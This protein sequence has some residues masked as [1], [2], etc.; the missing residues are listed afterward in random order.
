MYMPLYSSEV[1][2]REPISL[3]VKNP[4]KSFWLDTPG[5][6]PLAEDGSTGPLTEDADVCIIGSGLTGIST[7]WHLSNMFKNDNAMPFKPKPINIVILEARQFGRNG[8]NLTPFLA[9]QFANRSVW[10]ALK[11]YEIERYTADALVS[12]ITEKNL[13]EEVGLVE[14]GHVTIFKTEEDELDARRELKL[15]KSAGLRKYGLNQELNYTGA[16]FR[17]H[18]LWPCK[19]VTHLFKDSQGASSHL[20]VRLHTRTPVTS[21][22]PFAQHFPEDPKSSTARRRRWTLHTPRGDVAC[23]YVVH[24]TNAYA[25]HLLP[26]LAGINDNEPPFASPSLERV[27]RTPGSFGIVPHRGQVGAVRASV[28]SSTLGWKNSW[29]FGGYDSGSE[30]W[31]PRHQK[32]EAFKNDT[33][34]SKNRNPVIILGGGRQAETADDSILN[35]T[36]STVLRSFLPNLFPEQ[37][38]VPDTNTGDTWEEEWTGIMGFTQDGDPFVGP[39]VVPLELS[40]NDQIDTKQYDGQYIAAGFSGHGMP[41][42]YACAQFVADMVGARIRGLTWRK[43]SWMP[44]RYLTWATEPVGKLF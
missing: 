6:N 15:A 39:V 2:L 37:F 41:R 26:F 17:S 9:G 3:P 29:G 33:G 11:S 1:E 4:T 27:K 35:S 10:E 44:A 12:F 19:L 18:N 13:V 30:Y 7:A 34:P 5:S 36:T 8:G 16:F 20:D 23:A 32:T 24:A 31:F 25:S 22:T 14:G 21:V 42:T 38:I 43:P 28:N 40:A